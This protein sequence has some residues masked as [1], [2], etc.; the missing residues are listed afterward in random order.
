MTFE[1]GKINR[2]TPFVMLTVDVLR[3]LFCAKW[4]DHEAPIVAYVIEHSWGAATRT[5]QKKQY[6][7][8]IPCQIPIRPLARSLGV[9]FTRIAEAKAALVARNVLKPVDGGWTLNK[10]AGEWLDADGAARL[11][12]QASTYC[13]ADLGA[14]RPS[15]TPDA[16]GVTPQR[17]GVLRPSVTPEPEIPRPDVPKEG[18]V[19]RP[20][21][22]GVTPQRNSAHYIGRAELDLEEEELKTPTP[23]THVR[24]R[25]NENEIAVAVAATRSDLTQPADPCD[26]DQWGPY[27][28]PPAGYIAL[29]RKADDLFR[30]KPVGGPPTDFP[31]RLRKAWL[32]AD[33]GT[34]I[35][36][37]WELYG[38]EYWAHGLKVLLSK[39]PDEWTIKFYVGIVRRAATV[40][41]KITADPAPATLPSH[42]YF[43]VDPVRAAQIQADYARKRTRETARAGEN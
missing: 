8:A 35:S 20:S 42:Q 5:S 24:T 40:R 33:C 23:R 7:D 10:N 29:C 26:P 19:L 43:Q 21:V 12:D 28:R 4:G 16:D 22:T 9:S 39:S 14:L 41:E 37:F 32:R 2:G 30:G 6:R 17:N 13:H 34:T 27:N 31:D 18:G 38:E 25:G 15:V 36:N 3:A 1:W 11:S